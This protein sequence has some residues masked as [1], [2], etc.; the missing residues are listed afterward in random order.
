MPETFIDE[1]KKKQNKK[2]EIICNTS[3]SMSNQIQ[4]PRHWLCSSLAGG[5]RDLNI[6]SEQPVCYSET[7]VERWINFYIK[8]NKII[9]KPKQF[10]DD[11]AL[12]R[13]FWKILQREN[14]NKQLLPETT[15]MCNKFKVHHKYQNTNLFH[16]YLFAHWFTHELS[17]LS[18][19]VSATVCLTGIEQRK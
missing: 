11:L 2:S 14:N 4:L 7:Y 18:G 9:A 1:R 16:Y 3:H 17:S 10:I 19:A 15:A 6:Q 5:Q 13:K 12:H 8:K